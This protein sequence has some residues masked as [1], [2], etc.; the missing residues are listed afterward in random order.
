MEVTRRH[1][2]IGLLLIASAFMRLLDRLRPST[3]LPTTHETL[4]AIGRR[5]SRSCSE[6][7]LS[8]IASASELLLGRLDRRERAALAR[9]YLR[10]KVD[11]PVVVDVA[12]PVQVGPVLDRRPG[13]PGDEPVARKLRYFLERLSEDV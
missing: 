1:G 12:V 5:L 11:S 3:H 2:R 6:R 13:F 9:G 7:D 8:V 4:Q 10:F